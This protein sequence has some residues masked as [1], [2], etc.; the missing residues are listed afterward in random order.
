MTEIDMTKSVMVQ[1]DAAEKNLTEE[2]YQMLVETL[3][4][5]QGFIK[6][7]STAA[8]GKHPGAIDAEIESLKSRELLHSGIGLQYHLYQEELGLELVAIIDSSFPYEFKDGK[9]QTWTRPT[10][11]QTLENYRY[12]HNRALEIGQE[13]MRGTETGPVINE[14]LKEMLQKDPSGEKVRMKVGDHLV[15]LGQLG[16]DMRQRSLV[17]GYLLGKERK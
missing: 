2:K 16:R 11:Q 10:Y 8:F 6:L 1:R 13:I 9:V 12:S 17:V 5:P 15:M 7:Y 14:V 4:S 3:V